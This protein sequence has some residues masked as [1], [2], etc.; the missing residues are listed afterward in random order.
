[1]RQAARARFLSCAVAFAL[2][3]AASSPAKADKATG[4]DGS[5]GGQVDW[6]PYVPTLSVPTT[7]TSARTIPGG[8]LPSV[9]SLFFAGAQVDSSFVY[10]GR[11]VVPL[12]GISGALAVGQ[13]PVVISSLDGSIAEQRPWTAYR[14]ECLL[15]GVGVRLTA[16][17]WT[18]GASVRA[19]VVG[20]GMDA[21]VAA[22]G[23]SSD[24]SIPS[25]IGLGARADV[26]G[27]RRLDPMNRICLF[28]A[29][30]LYELGLFNGGAA[31]LRWELG[32]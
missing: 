17:R 6:M 21:T 15:P 7:E 16:R 22:G 8:T 32:P 10:R 5:L 12:L 28:V 27:C 23:G 11:L 19:Y 1:M 3:T 9:G 14:F 4:L 31:G 13:S 30:T 26:E 29:P 25:R 2:A 18:L 20:V 24:L